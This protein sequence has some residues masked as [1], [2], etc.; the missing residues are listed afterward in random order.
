MSEDQ[1]VNPTPTFLLDRYRIEGFLGEGGLGTV[2]KAFDTRLKR[3]VAIKTLKRTS[4]A[5]DPELFRALE[6]RF[7]REAEAGSRM[8]ANP[9]L[10]T[11]YDLVTDPERTQYLILEFV[12]GGNL[13]DRIKAGPLPRAD[14]LRLT[15]D[16]A[17]GLQAAHNVGIVHRDVKPANIF[18]AEDGRAQVGDF[19]I[20]QIDDISG[21]TQTTTGHPGTPLYMSPEQAHSTGYVRPSSDQYSLGLVLFEMLTGTAYKRMETHEANSMLAAQPSPIRTLIARM[22]AIEPGDRYPGM[23]GVLTAIQA[24]Q[25][26]SVEEAQEDAVTVPLSPLESPTVHETPRI[27]LQ[28]VAPVQELPIPPP[29]AQSSPPNISRRAVLAGIG[30]LVLAGGTAGGAFLTFRGSGGGTVT[31]S[32]FSPGFSTTA[33]TAAQSPTSAPLAISATIGVTSAAAVAPAIA[34]VTP[35]SPTIP[36]TVGPAPIT[37]L[38]SYLD[39]KVTLPDEGEKD[40]KITGD[41]VQVVGVDLSRNEPTKLPSVTAPAGSRVARTLWAPQGTRLATLVRAPTPGGFSKSL[42]LV[43]TDIVTGKAT[44]VAKG[45]N[46]LPAWSPDSTTLVYGVITGMESARRPDLSGAVKPYTSTAYDIHLVRFDGTNDHIIAHIIPDFRCGGRGAGGCP[47]PIFHL[48]EADQFF[49]LD[50]TTSWAADNSRIAFVFPGA[51]KF[52]M[53]PD[54]SN[55]ENPAECGNIEAINIGPTT[56]D[57][58][59]PVNGV[60]IRLVDDADALQWRYEGGLIPTFVVSG[61]EDVKGA[62][63]INSRKGTANAGHRNQIIARLADGSEKK[64]TNSPTFKYHAAVSP[65]GSAVAFT[66]ITVT[67]F[68]LA[69]QSGYFSGYSLDVYV[70]RITGGTELKVSNTGTAHHPSWQRDIPLKIAPRP[71]PTPLPTLAPTVPPTPRPASANLTAWTDPEGRIRLQYPSSWKAT[72]DNSTGNVLEVDSPDDV[73]LFVNIFNLDRPASEGIQGFHQRHVTST[74]RSYTDGSIQTTRVGGASGAVMGYL[75][76]NKSGNPDPH[77]GKVWYVDSGGKQFVIEVYA[78]GTSLRRTDEINAIINSITFL[79]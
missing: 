16:A 79:R 38:L 3:A 19:G 63:P 67:D 22:L 34:N 8:G 21:R 5:T 6:E 78:T 40:G 48:L 15:A 57:P 28:P 70:V 64:I 37:S 72:R 47:Y 71:T 58:Y 46:T 25:S 32:P 66:G 1:T 41:P 52:T 75:S 45:V 54:G 60:Q 59:T 43:V 35:V 68:D 4:Y 56:D 29:P 55:I 12:P 73:F 20:A 53:R 74:T 30:G 17:R 11:V 2:V 44:T 39:G 13:A 33:T 69:E 65:D 27:N 42:D 62:C 76:A 61:Y 14:A 51:D 23:A 24:I 77:A 7:A 18:L 10:V 50:Q 36:G 26:I 31:V 49:R 9:N